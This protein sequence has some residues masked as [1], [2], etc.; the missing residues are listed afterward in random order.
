MKREIVVAAVLIC[1]MAGCTGCASAKQ[2][3]AAASSS[4][5]EASRT[6]ESTQA[7]AET[8][9]SAAENMYFTALNVDEVNIQDTGKYII[10]LKAREGW[11]FDVADQTDVTGWLVNADGMPAFTN[12]S[13]VAF[14]ANGPDF[15]LDITIDAARIA[16]FTGNGPGALY[17]MP[18]GGIPLVVEGENHGQYQAVAEKAGAYTIPAVEALG[19]IEGTSAKSELTFTEDTV[20]VALTM[21]KL[22]DSL[23]D[24]SASAITLLPGDGYYLSDYTFAADTLAGPWSGGKAEYTLNTEQFSGSFSE[25]GGDGNGN[26]YANIGV[27]GLTYNGLPLAAA[28]FR[29]H[30]YA[31][32]RT[33]AVETNGSLLNDTQPKWDTAAAGGIPVLCDAYPDELMITWPVDFDASALTAEDLTLTLRG[34]YGDALTLQPGTDFTVAASADQTMVSVNYIYW[35]SIPVYKTLGV[36]VNTKNLTW[37][38]QKYTVTSLSHDYDIASVYAYYVMSGGMQ[39]TQKWTYYGIDGLNEWEQALMIP[40]YTLRCT[41]D[42]GKVSYYTENTDGTGAF[43][44]QAEQALS[45]DSREDNHCQLAGQVA[46]FERVYD[47]TADVAVD[48]K[49]YTC[50]KVYANADNMPLAP[51]DC[52]GLTAQRGYV[53]GDSWEMHGRWPWQTFIGTGYQ[54]GSK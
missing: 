40:T 30:V 39:G 15:E 12:E 50:D 17:V 5:P 28:T 8:A 9:E 26:Y 23:I 29:I 7:S 2:A 4:T 11:Q 14:A 18:T 53:I 38:A 41:D 54:G 34:D 20:S 52:T 33:F 21:D 42:T 44:A 27:S 22:D 16:G 37:D 6:A 47:Q 25:L 3:P 48:G 32:G 35:A 43:T 13:G 24:S 36:E 46:S 49:S 31:F 10:R 1:A 51:A 45:F 19:T